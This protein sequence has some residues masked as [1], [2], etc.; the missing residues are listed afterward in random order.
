MQKSNKASKQNMKIK[1]KSKE[2]TKRNADRESS[3]GTFVHL[4]ATIMKTN[5]IV[6]E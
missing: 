5:T 2:K 1:Q 4:S 6:S 3:K